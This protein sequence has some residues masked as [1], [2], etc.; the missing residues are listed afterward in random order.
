MAKSS[1]STWILSVAF[2]AAIAPRL[3]SGAVLQ[4]TSENFIKDIAGAPEVSLIRFTSAKCEAHKGSVCQNFEPEWKKL[5]DSLKRMKVWTADID[6]EDGKKL[7]QN[8]Q[9]FQQGF[10][11][12]KL[13]ISSGLPAVIAS[14][15]AKSL[16]NSH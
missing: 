9:V 7:A 3:A 1:M 5:A 14:K 4:A 13:F 2:L 16:N 15:T 8:L 11:N 6:T 10:P 12:I